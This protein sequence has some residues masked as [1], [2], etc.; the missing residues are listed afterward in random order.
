MNKAIFA[1]V[2]TDHY[3]SSRLSERMTTAKKFNGPRLIVM[4]K[5]ADGFGF[6]MYTNKVLNGQYVKSVNTKS[7]AFRAGMLA[8][9]HVVEVDG[10]N[11][12]RLTHQEVVQRIRSGSGKSK[13]ILVIDQDT[14]KLFKAQG[15]PVTEGATIDIDT[16]DGGQGTAFPTS[17]A[18]A[19]PQ[20]RKKSKEAKSGDWASKKALF[21]NL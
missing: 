19:I 13:T 15:I 3:F 18:A 14:E 16:I 9:D 4:E 12:E 11:V 7:P 2:V 1:L 8:G 10:V 20:G 5:S 6:H 17:M 21:D